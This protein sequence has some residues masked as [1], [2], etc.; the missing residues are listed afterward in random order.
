[1]KKKKKQ[2]KANK[3]KG[4]FLLFVSSFLQCIPVSAIQLPAR[5][6]V[7]HMYEYSPIERLKPHLYSR[8]IAHSSD[9]LLMKFIIRGSNS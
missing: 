4:Y 2:H 9:L 7:I 5:E 1:M 8:L 3:R 6:K